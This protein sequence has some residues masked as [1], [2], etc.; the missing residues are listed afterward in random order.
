[1]P[2]GYPILLDVRQKRIV[3]VG[4]GAVAVR[5]AGKLIQA[6][7]TDVTAV[8]PDF[9]VGMPESVKKIAQPYRPEHLDGAV[10]AFASTNLPEVN[11]QVVEEC[12]R[13]NIW[14]NRA[15][16]E[17][18]DFS[19]AAVFNQ[20]GATV[21]V[22]ADSPALS[23]TIRDLLFRRWDNRWTAMA[24]AMRILRPTI[25]SSGLPLER[26]TILFRELAG[27]AAMDILSAGGFDALKEW[28]FARAKELAD[29]ANSK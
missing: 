8:A 3:I 6:G 12:R 5:K 22:W 2:D 15:D 4:G 14:V 13:R 29:G 26:R 10:L 9:S 20:S 21:A 18:G 17:G 7:A 27:D 1:M 28:T 24:D 23:A 19:S 11:A 25:L 16:D